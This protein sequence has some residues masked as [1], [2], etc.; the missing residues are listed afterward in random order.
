M[1]SMAAGVR[2]EGRCV[3]GLPP[4][5]VL[6]CPEMIFLTRLSRDQ[7]GGSAVRTGAACGGVVGVTRTVIVSSKDAQVGGTGPSSWMSAT[8]RSC[9]LGEAPAYWPLAR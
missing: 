4:G 6:A 9:L 5:G 3:G 8:S 7:P 1:L 2:S